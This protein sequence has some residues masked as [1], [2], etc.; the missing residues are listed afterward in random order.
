MSGRSLKDT[1]GKF[2][3]ISPVHQGRRD[4][5]FS[6]IGTVQAICH[7]VSNLGIS[8]TQVGLRLSERQFIAV[9]EAA[10]YQNMKNH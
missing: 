2:L 7:P 4:N 10:R 6:G 5:G 3:S 8:P 1:V 9:E